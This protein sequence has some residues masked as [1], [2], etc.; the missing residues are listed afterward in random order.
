MSSGATT[1]GYYEVGTDGSVAVFGSPYLGSLGGLSLNQ[2]IVGIASTPDGKGY[3][4]VAAD[5]GI[6]SFGDARFYGSTGS[7]HLNQPIVGMASTPDG[8]GYWLVAGDGGIFS[9]GDAQFL[10]SWR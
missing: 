8:K 3:W 2:P 10:G 4:L 6:F 9:F 7:L 1:G 5:G